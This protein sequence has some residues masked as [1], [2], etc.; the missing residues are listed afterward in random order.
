MEIRFLQTQNKKINDKILIF[1]MQ[2]YLWKWIYFQLS[3]FIILITDKAFQTSAKYQIYTCSRT[4]EI[5]CI[6]LL[7]SLFVGEKVLLN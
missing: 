7:L 1:W 6:R 5:E 3:S 2:F 4:D